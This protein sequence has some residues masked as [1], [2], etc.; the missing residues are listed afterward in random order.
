MLYKCYILKNIVLLVL[1]YYYFFAYVLCCNSIFWLDVYKRQSIYCSYCF[2]FKFSNPAISECTHNTF[3]VEFTFSA[4]YTVIGDI[5]SKAG[6]AEI[7]VKVG[8]RKH[9]P[10]GILRLVG[11]VVG[12][13]RFDHLH[14]NPL[15]SEA[16]K[17]LH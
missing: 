6:G 14:R 2:C 15:G 1:I 17:L 8:H 9:H 7:R 13:Q 5:T 12:R 3:F 4:T 10:V 11:K 16:A